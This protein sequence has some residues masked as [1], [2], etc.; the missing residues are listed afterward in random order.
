M[1]GTY[2]EIFRNKSVPLDRKHRETG[3]AGSESCLENLA[4][5]EAMLKLNARE[6]EIVVLRYY[7]GKTQMEVSDEVGISQ[8]QVSRLEK[9]ALDV[10]KKNIS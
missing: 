3:G 7:L 10:I 9:N 2:L 1:A 8:A 5:E 4:L 6:K